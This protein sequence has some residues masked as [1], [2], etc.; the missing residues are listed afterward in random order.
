MTASQ[1]HLKFRVLNAHFARMWRGKNVPTFSICK[2]GRRKHK[3]DNWVISDTQNISL[4]NYTIQNSILWN[5][6]WPP[7]NP[8]CITVQWDAG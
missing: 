1:P 2:Q 4:S 8:N 5:E 6:F 3:S 7:M